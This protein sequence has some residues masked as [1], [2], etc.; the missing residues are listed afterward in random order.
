ML[1]VIVPGVMIGVLISLTILLIVIA[2]RLASRE[3]E[4][5][6][7][8]R[9]YALKIRRGMD[10]RQV[11]SLMGAPHRVQA[12]KD[13]TV[14]HVYARRHRTGGRGNSDMTRKIDVIFSAERKVIRVETNFRV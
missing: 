4:A 9:A 8:F 6:A 3:A 7:Q 12:K 13:G 5:D 11:Q 1:Q 14:Q 2:L 10:V